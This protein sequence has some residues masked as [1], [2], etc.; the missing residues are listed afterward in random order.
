MSNETEPDAGVIHS[1][2]LGYAAL[3]TGLSLRTLLALTEELKGSPYDLRAPGSE[4][5]VRYDPLRL[6]TWLLRH[7]QQAQNNTRPVVR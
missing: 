4:N 7:R 2:S 6:S 3:A 1:L 5:P